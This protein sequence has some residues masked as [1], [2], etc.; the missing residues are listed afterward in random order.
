M[1]DL[2]DQFLVAGTGQGSVSLLPLDRESDSC[3]PEQSVCPDFIE[4]PTRAIFFSFKRAFD[5][6]M[7]VGALCV[8]ALLLPLIALA[9]KLDSP[10]PIFFTQ[11]RVGID[12]RRRCANSG[13]PFNRRKVLYP[14]R[15]FKLYKLRTMRLDAESGGPRWATPDDDRIT[16]FGRFLRRSRLDEFP[17]FFNVLRGEM[18]VIGPRP[19]R[20]CFIRQLEPQVINYRDRLRVLPGIT[21]LAQILNGYDTDVESVRRKVAL[22]R[23]YILNIG[24]KIDL[25]IFMGTFKVL[26]GGRGAH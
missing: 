15:P 17:Q 21:G 1:K 7:A 22:D 19:E 14:G 23:H 25:A 10:G 4:V 11:M 24:L 12:R 2:F 20:L 6:T 18:S 8:F 26:L 9:I 16:R 3:P 13:C 5:I